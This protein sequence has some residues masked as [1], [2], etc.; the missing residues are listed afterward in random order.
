MVIRQKIEDGTS[1]LPLI[2]LYLEM[3]EDQQN[4]FLIDAKLKE[5]FSAGTYSAY[6]KL[7]LVRWAGE[8]A[9]IF[10]PIKYNLQ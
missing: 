8:R 3:N 6:A 7:A 5:T 4:I 1:L 10:T 9:W 2:Q